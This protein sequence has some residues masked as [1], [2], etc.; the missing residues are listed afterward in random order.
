[1]FSAIFW[2]IYGL[3]QIPSDRDVHTWVN[4]WDILA[5]QE[6][7]QHRGTT[8]LAEKTVFIHRAKKAPKRGRPSGGLATYFDNG[9][10]GAAEFTKLCDESHFLCIRVAATGWSFIVGNVYLPLHSGV[11]DDFVE[12]FEAQLHSII[13]Q[14]PT[15]PFLIGGDFN[16]HLF[17]PSS[18]PH[19]LQFKDMVRQLHLQDFVILPLVEAPFTYRLERSFSTIDYILTRCFQVQEFK[20][21]MNFSDV[22]SHRPLFIRLD[23]PV[24]AP[25]PEVMLQ[26]A[27]G[28]AYLRSPEKKKLLQDLLRGSAEHD[29]DRLDLTSA[30]IQQAYDSIENCFE[31]CTK[32]T[33][34]KPHVEGWESHLDPEDISRLARRHAEVLKQELRLTPDSTDDDFSARRQAQSALEELVRELKRKAVQ[35]I[36]VKEHQDARQHAATWKL[37][38]SFLQKR[39]QP[40][41]PPST[42]YNHYRQICQVSTAPLFVDPVPRAFVGPLTKEG[43]DL[44]DD[45]TASEVSTVLRDT[46]KKS[47]PGPGGLTPR[48]ISAVL[49]SVLLVSF[50]ARFLT[51]CFRAAF[52]P[53]QWRTSENFVLYKGCGVTT[54]V[55]S[56]RAISLTQIMAKVY[57][58]VLFSR[59]WQWFTRSH[60]FHLPQ[61]RFRPKS[62]M[63]DAVFTL[64]FLIRQHMVV[65]KTPLS[66]A[67]VD[68]TKAFP[69]LNRQQLFEW[70][71]ETRNHPKYTIYSIL[72]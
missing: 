36:A 6:T 16:C 67:F 70:L 8:P 17:A 27:K 5:V 25:Y 52:T 3:D 21:E 64:L 34:R 59:V 37:L 60:L 41:V 47:A 31:L 2:N 9:L 69:S 7:L 30:Q 19:M 10:F 38:S 49:N 54:D 18:C 4:N 65:L 45:I 24:L 23:L 71:V 50:F 26:P 62:S 29:H 63:I 51:R 13:E 46:N 14:F 22:T 55:S 15:D 43:N 12:F 66:V 39:V 58:Q 33:E 44:N 72:L 42:M 48:L 40:E 1:M 20:V 11:H 68:I 53:S 32:R 57:E 56:F 35:Q 61:F 28:A